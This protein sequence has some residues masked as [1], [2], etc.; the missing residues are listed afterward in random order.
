[1]GLLIPDFSLIFWMVLSFAIVYFILQKYAWPSVL[2]ALTSR[3]ESIKHSLESA[4]K[5]REEFSRLQK[6]GS[7]VLTNARAQQEEIMKEARVLKENIIGEARSAAQEETRKQME[8]A[9]IMIQ[10]EKEKAMADLK[11]Q[12][13]LLSVDIAE[14]LLKKELANNTEQ[15][16]L[17]NELLKDIKLS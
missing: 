10:Q 3:E 17:I 2:R 11:R 8:L 16:K 15:E 4:Q 9:K 1:M 14:Q 6:E 7:L 12:A 13:A 5:A